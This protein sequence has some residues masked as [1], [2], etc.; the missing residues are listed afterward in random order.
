MLL[1]HK[2]APPTRK[3]PHLIHS[4]NYSHKIP[5][6]AYL[7]LKAEA[8][9]K[10]DDCP[11][12]LEL[13]ILPGFNTSFFFK[14]LEVSLSVPVGFFFI[15]LEDVLVRFTSSLSEISMSLSPNLSHWISLFLDF[16]F[17][18]L[19]YAYKILMSGVIKT[20]H[21]LKGKQITL[22]TLLI[23]ISYYFH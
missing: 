17:R 6:V 19:K 2:H 14:Y 22:C 10:A 18:E 9:F 4:Q 15:N 5:T 1:I 7:L 11:E 8:F 23:N 21:V 13:L 12:G 20:Q 3:T 16:L